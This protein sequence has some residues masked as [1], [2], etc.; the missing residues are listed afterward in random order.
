MTCKD[1]DNLTATSADTA[2][3]DRLFTRRIVRACLIVALA[4]FMVLFSTGEAS[5]GTIR[6]WPEVVVVNDVV[7]V[8]DVCAIEGIASK[9]QAVISGVVLMASPAPGGSSV[10]NMNTLRKALADSGV[11]LVAHSVRGAVQCAIRRPTNM[12]VPSHN[13]VKR[14]GAPT[15]T[16][17]G[18]TDFDAGQTGG[19]SEDAPQSLR[20]AVERYFTMQFARYGGVADLNFDRA[21]ESMLD[22]SGAEYDFVVS[23]RGQSPLG[24]VR[25]NVSVMV[26]GHEVQV[27]PL[28]VSVTMLRDVVVARMPINDK[29]V[30]SANDVEIVRMAFTRLERIG[31]ADTARVIGQR[32]KRYLRAGNVIEQNDLEA[33]P[34]VARGQIVTLESVVGAISIVTSAKATESGYLGDVITLRDTRDRRLEHEGV[35]TGPGRVRVGGAIRAGLRLAE[36]R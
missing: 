4:V 32:A 30:V 17:V 25:V 24:L 7:T 35:V 14:D 3:I 16:F 9:Q 15:P 22:L 8:S 29:A 36:G 1:C 11:N 26:K 20:D 31:L 18:M 33:L 10:L 6:L 23:H 28:I 21:A 2:R 34:L 5:G 12:E 19:T 13:E 27:V